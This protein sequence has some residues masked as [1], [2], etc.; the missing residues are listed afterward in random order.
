MNHNWTIRNDGVLSK[1]GW[2]CYDGRDLS[3][4]I[5]TTY[6]RGTEVFA[7]GKVTGTPGHGKLASKE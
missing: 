5:E 7:G 6:V 3:A 4:N 1:I 2:T